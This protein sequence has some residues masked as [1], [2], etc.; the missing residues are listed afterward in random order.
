M[1]TDSLSESTSGASVRRVGVAGAARRRR[2]FG[3]PGNYGSGIRR[4]G[5]GLRTVLVQGPQRTIVMARAISVERTR[6]RR[7]SKHAKRCEETCTVSAHRAWQMANPAG[8]VQVVP[9]QRHMA[10]WITTSQ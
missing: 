7:L 9:G 6:Q 8:P 2:S 3:Q 1:P 10:T 4:M 5:S